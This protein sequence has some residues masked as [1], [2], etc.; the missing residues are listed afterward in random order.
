[1]VNP[2]HYKATKPKGLTDKQLIVKYD[3]GKV[4]NFDRGLKLMSRA[5]S[6]TTL[7]KQKK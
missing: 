1:M 4:I 3:T 7:S 6:Q 2:K 5:S